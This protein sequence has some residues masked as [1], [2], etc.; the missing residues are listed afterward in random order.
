[1]T[2]FV[3]YDEIINNYNIFA[4]NA[5]NHTFECNFKYKESLLTGC[6]ECK[7]FVNSTCAVEKSKGYIKQAIVPR[8]MTHHPELFI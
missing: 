1:M 8:I 5:E 3:W 6:T 7:Y 2:D 4:Y